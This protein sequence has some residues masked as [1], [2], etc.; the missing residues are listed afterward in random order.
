MR[1]TRRAVLLISAGVP[2]SIGLILLNQDLAVAS[3]AFLFGACLLIALDGLLALPPSA[4]AVEVEAPPLMYIGEGDHLHMRAAPTGWPRAVPC[5]VVCDLGETLIPA[6]PNQLWLTGD[7]PAS[8][9]VPLEAVRRGEAEVQRLWFG[10]TGPFG[11]IW[12]QRTIPLDLKLAVVPNV[13]A[14]KHAAVEFF[15]RDALFGQKAQFQQGDGS[16]FDALRDY[17]PGLDHRSIDWKQSARHRK[18]VCKEFQT[19]RNHP[20]ILAFDTGQL[21]REPLAGIPKLDHAVNAGLMLAYVSMRTGDRV[22][23]FGFDARVRTIHQPISGVQQFHRIERA[24]AELEYRGE[25]TNFTLGLTELLLRR[26]R[27]SLIVLFTDFV[28]TVTAEL[29]L[30]NVQRLAKRHLV[31]FVTLQDPG[32]FETVDAAPDSFEAVARTVVADDFIR[33]RAVVLNRLERLGVHCLDVPY[34]QLSL[35]LLNRYLLIRKDELV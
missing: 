7:A 4:L 14:V 29:M 34:G 10:W 11:L 13:R 16:E 28:D 33:D 12:K 25:E 18:L 6:P 1:P 22:G 8:C 23:V 30:A 9:T 5:D 24:T 26:Q 2:L 21:M 31:V 32:L 15:A 17:V 19:E 27:R 20:I 35:A 3:L